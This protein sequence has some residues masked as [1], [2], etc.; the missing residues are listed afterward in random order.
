MPLR[1]PYKPVRTGQPVLSLGGRW[2]RPQAL[3]P[4]TLVGPAGMVA[5]YGR[6]DTAADDTVFP[7]RLAAQVGIDLTNAPPGVASGIGPG[8]ISV[9]YAQVTL[10]I[11]QGTERHE[12][13]AWVGFTAARLRYP[14]LGFAGFLQFFTATF[15]G[16]LEH[17]ELTV[18]RLNP[19]T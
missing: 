16:D 5:G 13:T 1:Y 12:W 2:V 6:L 3:V 8:T 7:E 15:H 9:R 19:G 14:L 10:R 11:A 4:V 17:V 18:N